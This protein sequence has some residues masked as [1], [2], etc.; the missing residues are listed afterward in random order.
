MFNVRCFLISEHGS[1]L[2]ITHEAFHYCFLLLTLPKGALNEILKTNTEM[3]RYFLF[4]K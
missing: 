2:V 3:E 1:K 4:L